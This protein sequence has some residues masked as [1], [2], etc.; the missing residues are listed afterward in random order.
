MTTIAR[1]IVSGQKA[2]FQDPLLH[3][4]LDLTYVTDHIIIMGFPA[5]G[6]QALYRNKRSDV[7]R[8]LDKRH[9][10]L[11]RVYNFCP[12]TENSYDAEE[13]YG[14]V[15]RFPFPDHHVPPLSLIPLF[16]ADITEFLESDPDA[17]AVI[18]CKAGK[19]RSGTMTCC[20][21]VSLP[22]LP[23]APTSIKNYSNMQR[24]EDQAFTPAVT[25]AA[26]PATPA[27]PAPIASA[28]VRAQEST[29]NP[30]STSSHA[31]QPLDEH[32][33]VPP[34]RSSSMTL[35]LPQSAA[36]ASSSSTDTYYASPLSSTTNTLCRRPSLAPSQSIIQN[37]DHNPEFEIQQIS[38]RL[39]T[40]FDLHT[41]R[42]MKP[43]TGRQRAKSNAAGLRPSAH[44]TGGLP[45][46][47]T[48]TTSLRAL[49]AGP[50]GRSCDALHMSS[51]HHQDM[52]Y[53]SRLAAHSR[54]ST[55]TSQNPD[56]SYEPSSMVGNH[57]SLFGDDDASI[58][59]NQ[60][61]ENN[62][63]TKVPK[64]G[65]SIPSQRRW[66]GYWTRMLSGRDARL[67]MISSI[68]QPRRQIRILRISVERQSSPSSSGGDLLNR[69]IP[70]SDSLSVQ[71]GR[72]QDTLVDRLESWERHARRRAKAFGQHDPSGL[73]GDLDAEERQQK[74]YLKML[75][76]KAS[77]LHCW[78]G[79]KFNEEHEGK[80]GNWGVCV[81]AEAD[82]ARA[83]DWKDD[84]PQLDYFALFG[85]SGCR[86]KIQ[87]SKGKCKLIK[88][89]FEPRGEESKGG[90][91]SSTS[92][93]DSGYY[94]GSGPSPN[95]AVETIWSNG[96]K[97][98][99]APPCAGGAAGSNANH[100]GPLRRIRR[101]ASTVFTRPS[102]DAT[103]HLSS[104]E[105][106]PPSST[107]YLAR[108]ELGVKVG[109]IVDADRELCVKI[110]IGRTGTKHSKLPDVAS[111]G[112]CWFIPSFED[113]DAGMVDMVKLG[114]RTKIRFDK[115]EI[116]F[117]KEPMGVVAVE[118]EWEW[119]S[120]G[121]EE[122]AQESDSEQY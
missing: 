103:H 18:H 29:Q 96:D 105:I 95:E 92:S 78:D 90:L 38:Q 52:S 26:T 57:S 53:Q 14:R 70:H 83:F 81:K 51:P 120:V 17:T 55:N 42:R 60:N 98:Q 110:L 102:A 71:L 72:Y 45:S 31:L 82:R 106:T 113:P 85:E 100:D 101:K 64:M 10:D 66:V 91:E 50:A 88:Y 77:E 61:T 119:V 58:A 56:F 33:P 21:L 40:I 74:K 36:W 93:A 114:N 107:A 94:S 112:W 28:D 19:G 76:R 108:P 27:P 68:R 115:T 49:G 59:V 118:V 6:V 97:N 117:R 35:Q 80:I 116:D 84:Q 2:R 86:E 20:Y 24:P 46:A 5:S 4:D 12:L 15:S 30:K 34:A 9:N 37:H 23:T 65:V 7:R 25:P 8:F 109:Q 3:L 67:S 47:A 111:A 69:I 121:V 99:L 104:G 89:T 87:D 62:S 63:S 16:V 43:R 41:E 73:A 22:Y 11:Y 79:N 1:R 13:F 122:D 48:S 54:A 32:A 39:Q 44:S 75:R